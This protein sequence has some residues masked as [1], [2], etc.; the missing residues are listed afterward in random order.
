MKRDQLELAGRRVL[1]IED[2]SMVTMLIHD[3]LVD[4]GCE[5]VGSASRFD[6]AVEKARSLSFE[7]AILDLNLS[8][9]HT[10]PIAEALA[11]RK[12]AFVF[13]TGYGGASLPE[14]LRQAPILHKPFDQRDLE[15]ALRTALTCAR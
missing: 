9:R 3:T 11:E 5:V 12:I 6:D 8:G 14:P 13:A 2:E 10:L 7:V 1:V 15:G 4:I